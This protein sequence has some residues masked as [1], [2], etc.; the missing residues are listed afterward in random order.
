MLRKWSA[1]LAAASFPLLAV[2]AALASAQ[3]SAAERLNGM[4][5]RYFEESLKLQPVNATF[6]GDNRYN[7]RYANSI[8]PQ[9]VADAI[10]RERR[11]LRDLAHIDPAQLSGTD[12]ITYD[13]FKFDRE[14]ALAGASFPAELMPVDQFNNPVA[15]FAVLGSGTSAQPFV[16]VKDYENFLRRTDEF[17]VF[18]DQAITNMRVGMAK[19]DTEPKIVMQKVLPQL[20]DLVT[21]KL[22]DSVFYGPILRLP[23]GFAAADRERL[24]AAYRREI[25]EKLN[26]GLKRLSDFIRRE[27]LPQCRDSVGW[28]ALPDGRAWY[29]Y[30]LHVF[31]TT[32][33]TAEDIH[34]L[35]LQE[36]GRIHGEMEDVRRQVGFGG[37]LH[38]FFKFVQTDPQ[39]LFVSA[40]D[41]LSQF[42]ATK[43]KVG[44]LL[45]RL[46]QDFPKADYEIR[47]VEPFRAAASAGAFYQPPSEDGS[48]P[49][50]F[51]LNTGD[52]RRIPRYGMETLLLHEA[53]P[54]HHFQ[55]TIAQE[56]KGIPRYR[57]FSGGSVY[58]E[59]WALY[60]ESIGKELGVFTDP[61]QYYGRLNDEML[62]A[63]RLVVD[64]GIHAK[65]WTR[66]QAIAYMLDNSSLAEPEVVAEVERYIAWPGQATS[67]KV[68]QLHIRAM[69]DRAEKALGSRFN[70]KDFHSQILLDGALPMDVLDAKIDRWITAQSKD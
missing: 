18:L 32:S 56:L 38:A 63:M 14:T 62:R 26:P 65:G 1:L 6:I 69:R 17:L 40:A 20:D 30:T 31:T 7:D 64:T 41:A 3:P 44:E 47:E 13:V 15:T 49:G 21:A 59:G 68:G 50:I 53:S 12:R 2:A 23:A 46:F 27:Y 42:R 9:Y 70:V 24:T 29:D 54:G 4:V 36:V 66:D 58:T 48:R 22:E 34:R 67:Y 51:Y 57:R 37:D 11:Y 19:G 5:D 25:A 52:L 10:K 61:Y 33:M 39:F 8:S 43:K 16:T 35:G 45:P 55:I 60:C 28:A